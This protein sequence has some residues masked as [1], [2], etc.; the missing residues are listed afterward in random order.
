MLH[1]PSTLDEQLGR[2]ETAL[3]GFLAGRT[4]E[5]SP[6]VEI[7]LKDIAEQGRRGKRE[8]VRQTALSLISFCISDIDLAEGDR[9]QVALMLDSLR[10]EI[11]VDKGH[12]LGIMKRAAKTSGKF[13]G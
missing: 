12:G 4:N 2:L 6:E 1:S 9:E 11:R 8:D 13:A 3:D 10:R 5:L 7:L